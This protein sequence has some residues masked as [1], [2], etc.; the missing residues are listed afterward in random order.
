V[1]AALAAIVAFFAFSWI[2]F[3]FHEFARLGACGALVL[4]PQLLFIM[5]AG[6]WAGRLHHNLALGLLGL[7]FFARFIPFDPPYYLDVLG[8]SILRITEAAIPD[9]GSIPF[10]VPT[11]FSVSRLVFSAVGMLL[12]V[13]GCP[14]PDA[15][16]R[17][18][19]AIRSRMRPRGPEAE[20]P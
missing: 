5:G 3:G 19:V 7:L 20:V 9:K 15:R 11:G 8:S 14:R 16:P 18:R 1:L 10:V 12:I 13:A 17:R 2:V 6:L 4:I